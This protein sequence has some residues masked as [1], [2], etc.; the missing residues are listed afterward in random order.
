MF[1]WDFFAF[2][3]FFTNKIKF[4]K[5]QGDIVRNA[6]SA[7]SFLRQNSHTMIT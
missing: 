1:I 7:S 2:S 5:A 3:A 6:A 4:D